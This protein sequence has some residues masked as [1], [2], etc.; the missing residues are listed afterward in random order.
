[1]DSDVRSKREELHQLRQEELNL[2]LKIESGHNRLVQLMKFL[3][4]SQTN[5]DQ[6]FEYVASFTAAHPMLSVS[7]YCIIVVVVAG[8]LLTDDSYLC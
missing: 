2:E 7:L 1:M 5:V 8:I 3:R 4:S 6:V